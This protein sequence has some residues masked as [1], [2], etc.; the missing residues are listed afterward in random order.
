MARSIRIQYPGAF[1]HVMARGN[2]REAIFLDDDDRRFFL[3]ALGEACEKTGW[4][5]HA[6][7]LMR[8][9]YHLLCETPQANLVA[10]MQWLQNTFTRRFN[11]RHRAW[12]RLFGDRYKA[13][14][15]EGGQGY[16]YE[17]L[18]DYIHLNPI[19]AGIVSTARQQGV[20]DF[21]WSS[22]AQGYALSPGKRASWLAADDG[23]AAF[24]FPDTASG[25]RRFVERLNRRAVESEAERPGD[26][27]C[28]G[29]WR[30]PPRHASAPPQ[31]HSGEWGAPPHNESRSL[32]SRMSA[33]AT[34]GE[35]GIG[36]A[37][38][39]RRGC[40]RWPTLSQSPRG[41]RIVPA[42]CI[43]RMMR[44]RPN[45]GFGRAL[46]QRD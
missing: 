29:G 10:G 9:H 7:V 13:V 12:G 26:S 18:M 40:W 46:W 23:L 34:C 8:N 38:S 44:S 31:A 14:L 3:T 45:N 5:V 2:R 4:K 36:E 20:T 11:V 22:A 41:G 37:R 16:Y 42:A 15:V 28:F 43:T 19:R 25:R 32:R 27:P 39:L 1:Y 21:E 33:A 35:D 17:T 6:W 24:G 30:A